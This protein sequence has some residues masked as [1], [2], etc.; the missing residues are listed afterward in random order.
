[1]DA[2]TVIMLIVAEGHKREIEVGRTLLQ[3]VGCFANELCNLGLQ[4][5][6]HYYGPYSDGLEASLNSAV[7]IGLVEESC[8]TFSRPNEQP[9]EGVR[10]EYR[11]TDGGRAILNDRLEEPEGQEVERV[12]NTID[13]ILEME[14]DYRSLSVAAKLYE[15]SKHASGFPLTI[16]TVKQ[17]AEALGWNLP[18]DTI[19]RGAEVLLK[20]LKELPE[21]RT[22]TV[23]ESI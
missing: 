7:A 14:S 21:I 3:K 15:L 5:R 12:R 11:L 22:A 4:Y 23:R 20:L 1:M 10:Y 16:Q 17:E 8:D 6:S 19:D 13:R 2:K 9:F 18:P